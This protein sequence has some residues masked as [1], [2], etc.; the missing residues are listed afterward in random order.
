[1]QSLL[2]LTRQLKC[3]CLLDMRGVGVT[4]F[5]PI[6]FVP[7]LSAPHEGIQTI[8][9]SS[10]SIDPLNP[11]RIFLRYASIFSLVLDL[12]HFTKGL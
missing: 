1:M 12:G 8:F 10:F 3:G 6:S 4:C 5:C 2:S 11:P 7:N 9:S